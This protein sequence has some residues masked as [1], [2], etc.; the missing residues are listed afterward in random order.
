MNV[1]LTSKL[2]KHLSL[3]CELYATWTSRVRGLLGTSPT[4]TPILLYP[5]WSI[6]TMGMSYTIDVAFI[7]CDH[8]VVDIARN[9]SPWKCISSQGSSY[10]LERPAHES[11]W[12]R[13]GDVVDMTVV[14]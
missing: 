6:H 7:S 12:F 4:H 14:V 9:L 2:N 8:I 5:C 13:V 3:T 10:V 1:R 11:T